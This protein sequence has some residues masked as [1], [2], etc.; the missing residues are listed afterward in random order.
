MDYHI[1]SKKSD[2][3]EIPSKNAQTHGHHDWHF[4]ATLFGAAVFIML[5]LPLTNIYK[6]DASTSRVLGT[7]TQVSEKV[8]DSQ[9]GYYELSEADDS[10]NT[11][12]FSTFVQA[13]LSLFE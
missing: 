8:Y 7:Q 6:K 12:I 2:E 3:A 13:I 9:H 10:V 1:V 5:V 11:D 4:Q